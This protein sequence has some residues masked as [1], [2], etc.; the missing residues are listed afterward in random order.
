MED[1]NQFRFH[2]IAIATILGLAILACSTA[3]SPG[4]NTS[5]KVP[6]NPTHENMPPSSPPRPD[7][8]IVPFKYTEKDAGDGWKEGVVILGFINITDYPLAP[9]KVSFQVLE[10]TVE[11]I[12]G[13]TYPVDLYFAECPWRCN[14]PWIPSNAFVVAWDD[15]L[16]V[17]PQLPI[18][19]LYAYSP[20]S[21]ASAQFYSVAY[22]YNI[23]WFRFAQAAHPTRLILRSPT[24]EFTIE[25]S[26]EA[27]TPV[28]PAG[29]SARSLKDLAD[30]LN[31]RNPN[32]QI[33]FGQCAWKKHNY[34]I[35]YAL[36]YTITNANQFDEEQV[37]TPFALWFPSGY[38]DMYEWSHPERNPRNYWLL[39]IQAGPGQTVRRD[40]EMQARLP[41]ESMTM[42]TYLVIYSSDQKQSQAYKLECLPYTE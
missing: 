33:T 7:F 42:P 30:E 12:E 29:F 5:T 26:V 27:A 8:D 41:Q 17:P 32:L 13:K 37:D 20:H 10:A 16:P 3:Y 36:P 23:A 40:M 6:T 9:Q 14:A 31:R 18:S 22:F 21:P 34:N 24:L 2:V 15:L 4:N 35:S 19:M 39:H 28:P 1:T 25:L 38:Y 11:T